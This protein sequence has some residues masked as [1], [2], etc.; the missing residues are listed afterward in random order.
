VTVV[1]PQPGYPRADVYEDVPEVVPPPGVRVLRT[2][3]ASTRARSFVGRGVTEQR[4][5]VRLALAAASTRPDV[6]VAS[7]PSM[8]LGPAG[9]AL[10]RM[11]R[12]PFV[13]DLRDITWEYA[14][15][16]TSGS[17]AASAAAARLCRLMWNVVARADLVVAATPGIAAALRGRS[18]DAH[19]VLIPNTIAPQLLEL[20]DPAEPPSSPRPLVTYAGLVG[21]AQAIG[22][23]CDVAALLPKVDFAI[24]GDGAE[25]NRVVA[26]ARQRRLANV[27]FHGYLP[28]HRL[29]SVYYRS[30]V[31]FAQLHAS[32]LH[33]STALPSKLFEYMAAGR[34]IVYAGD[35][36]A[37][38]TI[39]QVGCGIAV[40]P[41]DA[42]AIA[43]AIM[44]MLQEPDGG[45]RRALAG[46]AH[47]EAQPSREDGMAA[48]LPEL[49]RLAYEPRT[50]AAV[51]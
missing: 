3:A 11:H 45:R 2:R 4:L 36:L 7:S 28:P 46:R 8:F 51:A 10:A 50:A 22:V 43:A 15:E 30:H 37:A 49:R 41:G 12:V 47:A 32:E 16:A 35:G 31:L 33:T 9:A 17:R 44:A 26:D 48:L 13:W 24:V 34:P 42:D 1:A 40:P 5:A 25:H 38:A 39:E 21:R 23:L 18:R 20:L 19:V 14:R 6:V 27:E 29:A